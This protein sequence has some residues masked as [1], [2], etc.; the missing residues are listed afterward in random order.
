MEQ[1]LIYLWSIS[2]QI[3][4]VLFFVGAASIITVIITLVTQLPCAVD[5]SEMDQIKRIIL[6]PGIIGVIAFTLCS[7][8]PS[9][10]DLALIFL[11]PKIKQGTI[12]AVQSDTTKK[13]VEVLNGYLD[14]QLKELNNDS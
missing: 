10:Q 9:K 4:A 12:N 13:M 5:D 7:L 6:T 2:N 11:Y 8:I 3:S 14:K 1:F